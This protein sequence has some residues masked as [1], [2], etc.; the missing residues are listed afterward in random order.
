M[1]K[2]YTNEGEGSIMGSGTPEEIIADISFVI[3]RLRKKM[4][5]DGVK[6]QAEIDSMFIDGL[7]YALTVTLPEDDEDEEGVHAGV[8]IKPM[9][10]TDEEIEQAIR[11]KF[12]GK[13]P[14]RDLQEQ[15]IRVVAEARRIR[16]CAK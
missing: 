10:M 7:M 6:T 3:A 14:P 2:I 13:V 4:I 8:L 15:I 11:A 16:G 1:L 9:Q 12:D 5:E